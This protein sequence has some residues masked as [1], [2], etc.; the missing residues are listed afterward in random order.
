MEEKGRFMWIYALAHFTVQGLIREKKNLTSSTAPLAYL[1]AALLR[2]N[3]QTST[4]S[5]LGLDGS[6]SPPNSC[7]CCPSFSRCLLLE[8]LLQPKLM[9]SQSCALIEWHGGKRAG[10]E[11]TTLS[12]PT[13]PRNPAVCLSPGLG[14]GSPEGLWPSSKTHCSLS[15]SGSATAFPDILVRSVGST[16]KSLPL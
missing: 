15:L 10:G 3:V 14:E 5:P 13:F 2:T 7:T 1:L 6:G 4:T 11:V 9:L 12:P 8:R 16:V